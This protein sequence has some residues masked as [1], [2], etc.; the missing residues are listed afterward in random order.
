MLVERALQ[1]TGE[2]AVGT[3]R[4]VALAM[5]H[6]QS[7]LTPAWTNVVGTSVASASSHYGRRCHYRIAAA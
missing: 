6:I 4:L 7:E 3:D 5:T 2:A 1:V